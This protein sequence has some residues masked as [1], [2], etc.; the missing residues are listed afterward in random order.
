VFQDIEHAHGGFSAGGEDGGCISIGTREDLCVFGAD[1]LGERDYPVVGL[2][3]SEYERAPVLA[4][5]EVRSVVGQRAHIYL[6]SEDELLMELSE[7]VGASLKLDRGAARV[8]WPGSGGSRCDPTDHPVVFALEGEDRAETLEDF[9][10][11]FDLTR[12]RVRGRINL[13]EDG[14]AFLE[15]ELAR[16]HE[17][18][19][20]LHE[21]LRDEQIESHRQRTRAELAETRLAQTL[22]VADLD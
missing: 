5:R 9:C 7:M 1:I 10:Y 16:A 18:Q 2:T 11:Q 14:R 4:P 22:G 21:R 3:L 20:K 12:P 13:I 15:H 6:V 8:W 17:L 19:R